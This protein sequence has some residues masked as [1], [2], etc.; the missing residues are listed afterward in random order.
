MCFSSL[1]R[2]ILSIKH[3]G[4]LFLLSLP[5]SCNTSVLSVIF[6]QSLSLAL[7]NEKKTTVGYGTNRSGRSAFPF[8]FVVDSA[9]SGTAH[10]SPSTEILF[11]IFEEHSKERNKERLPLVEHKH[12]PIFHLLLVLYVIVYCI[13]ICCYNMFPC[14]KGSGKDRDAN[15]DLRRLNHIHHVSRTDQTLTPF[16]AQVSSASLS[17]HP[18]FIKKVRHQVSGTDNTH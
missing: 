12:S 18:L 6:V 13:E 10:P 15:E 14:G 4:F 3:G 9:A 1:G 2:V 5:F 7:P 8:R 16:T 11:P 17:L